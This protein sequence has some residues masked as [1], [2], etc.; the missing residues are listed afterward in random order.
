MGAIQDIFIA[1]G[2]AYLEKFGAGMPNAHRKAVDA[3]MSCRS[4]IH[5]MTV[6]ECEKC[7][8]RHY[9]YR[10]CGNRHCPTCQSGKAQDW[11]DAQL[12]KLLPG[13]YFLITFTV[14][15]EMRPFMRAHQHETY[16]AL[17]AAASQAVKVLVP[18]EKHIGGDQPGFFGVLH[19]WGRQMQYHPHIHYIAPGGAFNNQDG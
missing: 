4:P 18:D 16:N 9:I 7:G 6:Y 8:K 10:G 15:E 14:P 1:H 3:I 19:T 5:G 13:N 2:P 17:S 12:E 11:M